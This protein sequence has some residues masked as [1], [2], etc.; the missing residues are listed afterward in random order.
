MEDRILGY[1]KLKQRK[2][3]KNT[4]NLTYEFTDL[5]MEKLE[6]ETNRDLKELVL[7]NIT[8]LHEIFLELIARS[9]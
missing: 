4:G 6:E 5:I 8:D 1:V 3:N 9:E 7:E 2:D